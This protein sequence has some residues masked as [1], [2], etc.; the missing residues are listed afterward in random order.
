M[1]IA[2]TDR[3]EVIH[4]LGKRRLSPALK[5]GEPTFTGHGTADASVVRCGWTPFFDAFFKRELA[6]LVDTEDES[7]ISIVPMME[8]AAHL[9]KHPTLKEEITFAKRF[10]Q[11]IQPPP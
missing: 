3:G 1:K 8:A 11:S 4:H 9:K 10:I 6:L 5:N 7:A 2:T